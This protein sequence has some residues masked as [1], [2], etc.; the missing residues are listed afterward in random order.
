MDSDEI[1]SECNRKENRGLLGHMVLRV[2]K[3]KHEVLSVQ[4]LRRASC[5]VLEH[6]GWEEG[7]S[8]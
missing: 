3:F 1:L 6:D 5:C 2:E 7:I 8:W 4:L